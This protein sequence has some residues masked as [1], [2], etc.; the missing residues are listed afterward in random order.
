MGMSVS[1]V[2]SHN[3]MPPLADPRFILDTKADNVS[4]YQIMVIAKTVLAFQ[5]EVV[6]VFFFAQVPVQWQ[7]YLV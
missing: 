6:D 7:L 1:S 4:L 3:S 5:S 2:A